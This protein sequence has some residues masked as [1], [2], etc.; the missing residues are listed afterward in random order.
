[1]IVRR[2]R[3]LCLGLAAALATACSFRHDFGSTQFLCDDSPECP[4]SQVC[5]DGVCS[6][7]AGEPDADV[8]PDP[9]LHGWTTTQPLPRPRDYNF[10]QAV[11]ANGSILLVGGYDSIDATEVATVYRSEQSTD[12]M[13]EPWS[14]TEPL[15]MARALGG[16]AVA[17]DVLYVVGGAEF[18]VARTSVY[19]AA[20]ADNGNITGWTMTSILPTPR[21]GQVTVA[22]EGTVYAIGGADENDQ[23]VATVLFARIRESGA[24]DAWQE[25][26]PLPEPR[27]RAAGVEIGGNI[28]VIGGD[29]DTFTSRTTVYR[30]PIDPDDGSLGDWTTTTPLP[31][32]VAAGSAVVDA[33][34]IYLLGGEI[35]VPVEQVLHARVEEDGELDIWE[36]NVALPDPRRR[37]AA[38]VGG[39]YVYVLGG[40]G[41]AADV[42][43]APTSRAP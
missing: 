17:D 12:G 38:V 36:E 20:V 3:S 19:Y 32:A 43:V 22:A 1:M 26:F 13:L 42:F 35:A 5:V 29:D 8:P 23:R 30:A 33:G 16:V 6:S 18:G 2:D 41:G 34:H 15:P 31:E 24:L 14:E 7:Q 4:G 37:H 27:A 9:M 40:S 10:P 28:Y 39:D 21:K 11:F 25:G